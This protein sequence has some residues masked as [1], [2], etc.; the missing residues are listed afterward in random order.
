M[1]SNRVLLRI[2]VRKPDFLKYNFKELLFRKSFG[3]NTFRSKTA[4]IIDRQVKTPKS[5]Q[6]TKKK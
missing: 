6:S 4:E 3:A 5:Q 2:L 1:T